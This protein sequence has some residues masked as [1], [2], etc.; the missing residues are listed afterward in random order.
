MPNNGYQSYLENEILTADP[1]KLV[2][3][4]Y[5]GALDAID[6]AREALAEHDIRRRSRFI[7]KATKLVAELAQSLDHDKG[8][9]IAANLD[10]LYEYILRLLLDANVRQIEPPLIEA[11]QLLTTLLEGWL[12]CREAVDRATEVPAAAS[13]QAEYEPVC[14]TY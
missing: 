9:E 10:R 6:C 7:T 2:E 13:E 11:T 1:L 8:G 5:R 14:Y 3:L 12:G 4:L